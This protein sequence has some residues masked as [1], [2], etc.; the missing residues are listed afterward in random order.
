MP[1]IDIDRLAPE[2]TT[3]NEGGELVAELFRDETAFEEEPAFYLVDLTDDPHG[4]RRVYTRDRSLET[5]CWTVDARP[6]P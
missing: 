5:A 1:R 6:T 3:V 4:P 2:Q